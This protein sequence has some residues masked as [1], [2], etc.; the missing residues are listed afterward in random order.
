[1]LLYSV[2][3]KSQVRVPQ[4]ISSFSICDVFTEDLVM[5]GSVGVF[6][7]EGFVSDRIVSFWAFLSKGWMILHSFS[8]AKQIWTSAILNGRAFPHSP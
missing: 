8:Q 6:L 1:M 3:F 4:S 7:V 5:V 2:F